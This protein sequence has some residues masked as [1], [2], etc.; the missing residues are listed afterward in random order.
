MQ[1]KVETL[2]GIADPANEWN[3]GDG[4]REL[5]DAQ[6]DSCSHRAAFPT[7]TEVQDILPELFTEFSGRGNANVAPGIVA[8]T[9]SPAIA[10]EFPASGDDPAVVVER[11]RLGQIS[12][13]ALHA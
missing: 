5:S 9:F 2:P 7:A 4:V 8:G 3:L 6:L 13:C 11:W 12:R 10:S 1:C